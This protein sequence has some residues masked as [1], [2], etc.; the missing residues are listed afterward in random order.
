MS[1][2]KAIIFDSGSLISL[3]MSGLIPMLKDLRKIFNGK[4][5]ITE[6]VRYEVIDRP[7][8]TRRFELEALRIKKLLDDKILELPNSVKISNQEIKKEMNVL[9]KIA[10]NMFYRGDKHINIVSQGEIS[11]LALSKI[12]TQKKI[13]NVIC[14]DERTTRMLSE[15]PENLEKLFERKLHTDVQLKNK[16][17]HIFKDFKFIRSAE[18]AYVAY[19][20]S[21]F[22]I[23]DPQMLNAV[24]YSL[25]FKGC[26]I[27][28]AEIR[29]IKK[30]G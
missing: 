18:L 2:Q 28:G 12:L 15:K 24:L 20:K 23:K 21:L 17:F 26:A 3:G 19:K 1:S 25:K 13:K 16:N 6:Q 10:N 4:F 9:M 14:I 22:K 5:I 11:C 29:E 7:L 8:K 30:L 27:S